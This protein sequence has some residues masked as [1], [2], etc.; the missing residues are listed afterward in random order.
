MELWFLGTSAG[1]PTPDRNV[2][3]IALS[4]GLGRGTCWLFDCGEG[5]QHRLLHT[6]L[7]L[8][9]L[10]KL[11]VTHLHGDHVFGLPGLLSSRSSLGCETRLDLYGPHGLQAL[12]ESAL[13]V[14]GTHLGYPIRFQVS[15]EGVLYEDDGIRVE[16]ARLAHRIACVGYRVEERPR[17]GRL[18]TAWLAAQGV[19]AGPLYGKLKAGEDVT[20]ADGRIIR[21]S[22][23]V[24]EPQRGR[25]VTVL[26][27][28]RPCAGSL[29][30]AQDADVLVHEATFEHDLAEKAEAYGH[31]TARQA[32]ETARAANVRR[33]LLTHFSTRYKQEALTRL[34]A[35]A[36]KIFPGAEAACELQPYP[37]PRHS[38]PSL[39]HTLFRQ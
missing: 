9:R 7:K 12:V 36:Q 4:M 39:S 23:A 29:W 26:G 31:S 17:A 25:V 37:V 11:F 18:N 2:T 10:T 19:P 35:E 1:K 15:G 14:T 5:T 24:G 3:S 8:T 22:A 21:A 33:L 34:E 30:L 20:L 32:A 28:T 13:D 16:A 27:D 38:R 6:P